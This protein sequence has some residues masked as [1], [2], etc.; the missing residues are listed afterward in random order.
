MARRVKC[1]CSP[2]FARVAPGAQTTTSRSSSFKPPGERCGSA[3][4]AT[5]NPPVPVRR[6]AEA[7]SSART[8]RRGDAADERAHFVSKMEL[9]TSAPPNAVHC[10]TSTH[11]LRSV[12][13]FNAARVVDATTELTCNARSTRLVHRRHVACTVPPSPP[14]SRLPFPA[15]A[16]L[17]LGASFVTGRRLT[18]RCGAAPVLRIASVCC[19]RGDG[20]PGWVL[21]GARRVRRCNLGRY[22]GQHARGWHCKRCS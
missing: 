20:N 11:L 22:R 17:E 14:P 8:R 2:H 21:E 15:P 10:A 9:Y 3:M 13:H 19:S 6:V 18:W 16:C 7:A 5:L 1:V 4:V 12:G